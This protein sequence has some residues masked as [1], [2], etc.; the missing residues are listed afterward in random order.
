MKLKSFLRR[1][2]CIYKDSKSMVGSRISNMAQSDMKEGKGEG[3]G[4]KPLNFQKGLSQLVQPAQ[5]CERVVCSCPAAL[6]R[7][8]RSDGLV[9]LSRI[10]AVLTSLS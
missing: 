5:G 1:D 6:P 9:E 7:S 8:S 3:V 2:E 4:K 10:P